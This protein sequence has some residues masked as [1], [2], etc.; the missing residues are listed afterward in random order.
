MRPPVPRV[1]LLLLPPYVPR[2]CVP[3]AVAAAAAAA[4]VFFFCVF[5]RRTKQD[6][7]LFVEVVPKLPRQRAS[8]E[9]LM[10]GLLSVATG[11]DGTDAVSVPHV[12]LFMVDVV[13]FGLFFWPFPS[14]KQKAEGTFY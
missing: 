10:H 2:R 13:A 11:G 6:S 5:Y 7:S 9:R 12:K 4:A 1:S 14:S 8:L 3:A